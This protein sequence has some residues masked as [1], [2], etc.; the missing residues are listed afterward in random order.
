MLDLCLGLLS[1]HYIFP[2][3]SPSWPFFSENTSSYFTPDVF[4]YPK[5]IESLLEILMTVFKKNI[6]LIF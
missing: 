3:S 6:F 1:W 4:P 2:T 5:R